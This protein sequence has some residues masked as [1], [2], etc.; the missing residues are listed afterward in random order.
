MKHPITPNGYNALRRELKRL[1]AQRPELSRAI[2]VARAHGDISE[3]ADYDAAKNKSGMVEAKI[4]DI[5]DRLA[6]CELI[7]PRKIAGLDRVVFGLS[8]Q[9]RDLDS[10]EEKTLSLVGKD[11]PNAEKGQISIESPIARALIGKTVGD[12]AKVNLPGGA[13]EYELVGIFCSYQEEPLESE[14]GAADEA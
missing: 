3:N 12:V 11:E 5:E 2:E 10:D 13:R 4:R 1:K 8:V 7:D 6:N 9:I 14:A